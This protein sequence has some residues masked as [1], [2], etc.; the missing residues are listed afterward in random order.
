MLALNNR[1]REMSPFAFAVTVT[2]LND[3]ISADGISRL[4]CGAG[5]ALCWTMITC[6]RPLEYFA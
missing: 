5:A 2:F 1:R 6:R 3:L 4:Y